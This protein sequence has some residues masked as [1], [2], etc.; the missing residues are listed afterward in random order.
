MSALK[1]S[2]PVHLKRSLQ[3][4]SSKSAAA[5]AAEDDMDC[6]EIALLMDMDCMADLAPFVESAEG[7]C[8]G[9]LV[10]VSKTTPEMHQAS[11]LKKGFKKKGNSFIHV[12]YLPKW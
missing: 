8:L 1:I 11:S 2:C 9:A 5:A 4:M 10:F 7:A 3:L 12:R 6:F